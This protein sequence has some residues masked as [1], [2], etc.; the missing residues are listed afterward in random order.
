MFFFKT[1]EVW[2]EMD[3]TSLQRYYVHISTTLL[4]IQ[5]VAEVV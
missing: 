1:E 3:V 5:S 2:A 4:M